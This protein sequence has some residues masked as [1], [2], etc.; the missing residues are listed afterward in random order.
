MLQ[1]LRLLA[2][3]ALAAVTASAPYEAS[4]QN[5]AAA[6]QQRL[7]P[8]GTSKLPTTSFANEAMTASAMAKRS[9]QETDYP[10][11]IPDAEKAKICSDYRNNSYDTDTDTDTD[12]DSDDDYSR[13]ENK[14]NVV[15]QPPDSIPIEGPNDIPGEQSEYEKTEIFR[16]A[17]N[18]W[19]EE[20]KRKAEEDSML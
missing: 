11:G 5:D 17:V 7:D 13:S 16:R 4:F 15:A 1:A 6:A 3:A 18:I 2:A 14:K 10:H 9:P 12:S 19:R 8:N 20:M